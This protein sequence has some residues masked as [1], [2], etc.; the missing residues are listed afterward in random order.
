[1]SWES[2]AVRGLIVLE[3]FVNA[4][5]VQDS[6]SPRVKLF[7]GMKVQY[8]LAKVFGDESLD[9]GLAAFNFA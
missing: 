5:G 8:V 7:L 4:L 6:F 2:Y 1:M 9:N 3:H